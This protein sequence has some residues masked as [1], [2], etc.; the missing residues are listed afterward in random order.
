[1][2]TLN[3]QVKIDTNAYESEINEHSDYKNGYFYFDNDDL[4]VKISFTSD[5][6]G[7][8]DSLGVSEATD[9]YGEPTYFSISS[10]A[11]YKAIADQIEPH[12]WGESEAYDTEHGLTDSDFISDYA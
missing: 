11:E 8:V 2:T 10:E 5:E 3:Q 6:Q 9:A 4:T 1:M 7:N 12:L